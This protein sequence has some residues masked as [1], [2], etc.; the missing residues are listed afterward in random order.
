[1]LPFAF[2]SDRISSGPGTG[3]ALAVFSSNVA[4][5]TGNNEGNKERQSNGTQTR[6]T[7]IAHGRLSVTYQ[8]ALAG[9]A[10]RVFALVPAYDGSLDLEAKAP[11]LTALTK[12]L[13]RK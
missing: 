1:M 5:H 4:P 2:N 11:K 9:L 10:T 13:S 6:D 7:Q 3:G 8:H 12:K